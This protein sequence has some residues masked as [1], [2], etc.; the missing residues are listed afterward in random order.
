MK[1][2]LDQTELIRMSIGGILKTVFVQL[3][4]VEERGTYIVVGG[5]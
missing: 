4:G 1:G 3:R 2:S 5:I